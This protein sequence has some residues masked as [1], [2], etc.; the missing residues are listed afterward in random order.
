MTRLAAAL[1]LAASCLA[2]PSPAAESPVAAGNALTARLLTAEDAVGPGS[3][4]VSAGLHVV[5]EPGWK[6]YW[7][8]PGE[9]GLPPALDWSGSENVASVEMAYPAPERF[10]AFDIQNFGY[11]DEVV[12]PLAVALE[13]P[14]APARLAVAA[15]LLVCAD[16]CVPERVE[17]ALDLA[18]GGAG[19]DADA[20]ALLSDWV[21]RVPVSG[22][23]VG[24]AVEAVHLDERALTLVA[25]SE[26]PF[27]AVD[28]FPERGP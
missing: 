20:A 9:V 28:V 27:G 26:T 14:G 17:L 13:E 4:T 23:E 7:R 21:A 2:A 24:I 16:V 11:G 25:R 1:A 6:T 5:L 19:V 15:D 10:E 3:A 22:A 8:S 12:F 18:A